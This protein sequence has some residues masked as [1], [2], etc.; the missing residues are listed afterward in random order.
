MS[1]GDSELEVTKEAPGVL[2]RIVGFHQ[3]DEQH[4]V[5]DLE[6]GHAQH[7]RHDPPWQIRPWVTTPEGRAAFIGTPLQCLKCA[8]D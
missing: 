8:T 5:A 3:D 2:R 6:C 7:V 4:W 1:A